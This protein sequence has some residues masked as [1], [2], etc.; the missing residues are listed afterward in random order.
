ML[1]RVGFVS[2][3][4]GGATI[5]SF[6]YSLGGHGLQ[7]ARTMAV[8]T[9]V[10]AQAWYL[11]NSRF[12]TAS[13]LSPARLFSTRRRRSVLVLALLQLGCSPPLHEHLVRHHPASRSNTGCP[14]ARDRRAG[15]S[16]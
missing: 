13:S 16:P 7:A 4:I 9:L 6:E 5:A 15:L 14:T 2:L 3:L 1:W 8:N 12:L 10:I 11:F